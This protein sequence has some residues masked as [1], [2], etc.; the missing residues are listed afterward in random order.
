[1][2]VLKTFGSSDDF[3]L[4]SMALIP[5][6]LMVTKCLFTALK[7]PS[8]K[9]S[10]IGE[11]TF[12]KEKYMLSRERVMVF[13]QVSS[14]KNIK[15]NPEFVFRGKG[16]RT[17][18]AAPDSVNY[19]WSVSGSYRLD[20]MLKTISNLPNHYNPFTT[21]DF[22]IYVIDDYAV[23]LMSEIRKAL[24][25]RGYV[26]IVMGGGIT[27]FIQVNDTD[28]HHH[29]KSLYRNEERTLMLKKLEVDKNK[30][31][32]R[33]REQMIEMLLAAWK[34]T[35]VDFTAVFKKLFVTNAFDGSEDFMSDK[36]FSLIGDEML[37]YRRELLNSEVPAKL[38]AV[39]K[40]LIPP[41]GIRHAN[42][43]EVSCLI[44]WRLKQ[45]LMT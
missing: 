34:K 1:M 3:S 32:L 28:L 16:T 26:L 10:F 20:Q 23:H 43:K 9:L 6:L 31:P 33:N 19:Y 21:K 4:K 5:R 45:S 18:V 37:E 40:K 38:Q 39:I 22:A 2:I 12:I 11:Y 25:Q 15:L 30:V 29:L 36:L 35:D 42:M 27:G 8:K 41:K 7:V 17:K 24:Y 13:T 44:T 14:N